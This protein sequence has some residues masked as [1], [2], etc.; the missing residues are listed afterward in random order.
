M[1]LKIF[2][3]SLLLLALLALG[4][5]VFAQDTPDTPERSGFD[6]KAFDKSMKNLDLNLNLSMKHLEVTMNKLSIDLKNNLDLK[7]IGPEIT[8]GLKD[9]GKDINLSL[10]DD[11]MD[12]M[13]ENGE[14][15]DKVKTY[16]KSYN[17]DAGDKLEI[18]NKYGKV[19][20]N[21]WNKNEFKVDVQI[22]AY[23]RGDENAQKMIDA[24]NISD[25]KNGDVVSFKTNFGDNNEHNSIWKLFS[26]MNNN[27]K[28]EVNYIIY[29]PSKNALEI[30]N[31][32]GATELPDFDGKLEINSAYGSFSGKALMHTGNE[33]TVRYGSAS[34]ESL[35]TCQLKVGYGSLDL[36]SVDKLNSDISYSSAKIGK[37]RTSADINARYAGNVEVESL[38]KNFTSFTANASYSSVVVGVNNASNADFDITVHYGGFDYGGL[39]VD[40]TKKSPSDSE[41]GFHPTQNYKGRVGKGNPEKVIN[42]RTSYG[43]VKFE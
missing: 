20:V 23:A 32:Y 24:I 38:D 15:Q 16:S 42:I 5:P 14:I 8:A 18:S 11:K 13:V 6:S 27:R 43:S 7:I 4:R 39:P 3:P 40:I 17:V 31:R 19:V 22:K 34:I 12:E 21:T 1:K 26:N 25:S 28:V 41:R 33:I 36:G 10:N 35:S 29:M 37:V 30:D 2:K 9:I